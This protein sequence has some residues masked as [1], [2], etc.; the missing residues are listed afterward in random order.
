[1]CL[2]RD[3]GLLAD[4]A[5]AGA[6][7]GLVADSHHHHH[8][9]H[10]QD[11]H[12][13]DHHDHHHHHLTMTL[14]LS[15]T[16]KGGSGVPAPGQRPPCRLGPWG[17]AAGLLRDSLRGLRRAFRAHFGVPRARPRQVSLS[18]REAL[19]ARFVSSHGRLIGR[20]ISW[21]AGFSILAVMMPHRA[22]LS[23]SAGFCWL[24]GRLELFITLTATVDI[25]LCFATYPEQEDCLIKP[26]FGWSSVSQLTV[27]RLAIRQAGA[28]H[29]PDGDRRHLL[30]P[31][32]LRHLPGGM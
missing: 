24:F 1:V 28:V 20:R 9:H 30:G 15:D 29:H 7:A 3:S 8:H 17:A 32:L 22:P 21:S 2:H 12:H 25:T 18:Q 13:H 4:W 23:H 31:S 16:D 19:G 5:R 14:P 10:H 27:I 26:A 11:H 6:A